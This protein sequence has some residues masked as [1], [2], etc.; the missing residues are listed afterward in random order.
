MNSRT[1][2]GLLYNNVGEYLE[3]DIYLPSLQLAFEYQVHT[4]TTFIFVILNLRH[5]QE[6]HHY[7]SAPTTYRPVKETE[8]RDK[9]K[10]ELAREKTITLIIVPFW[11]DGQ[12]NRYLHKKN[13][14]HSY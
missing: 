3:L 4:T 8:E 14:L 9:R 2:A 5:E 7:L 6:R 12:V 11:W 10:K 1:E 13:N